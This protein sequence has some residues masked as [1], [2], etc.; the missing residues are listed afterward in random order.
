MKLGALKSAIRDLTTAPQALV[1]LPNGNQLHIHAQK[2]PLL[3]S[4]DN[5]FPGG[6]AIETG[7]S[8]TEGGI[9]VEELTEA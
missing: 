8:L 5:A 7:L 3:T 4:L 1:D 6:K 2:G 9:L